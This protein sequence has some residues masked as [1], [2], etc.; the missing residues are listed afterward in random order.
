MV[1]IKITSRSIMMVMLLEVNYVKVFEEVSAV[2]N[3]LKKKFGNEVDFWYCDERN[4]STMIMH[5]A[6]FAVSKEDPGFSGYS[7]I[8]SPKHT[9]EVEKDLNFWLKIEVT[10]EKERGFL[11]KEV[12]K[13]VRE[14]YKMIPGGKER[15]LKMP[16]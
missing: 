8:T 5:N 3:M 16:D 11:L 14:Y 12:T 15:L 13:V 10:N 6:P 4:F 7:I 2:L 1:T 9:K